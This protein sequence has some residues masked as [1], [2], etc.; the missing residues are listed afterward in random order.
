M[1]HAFGL[2]PRRVIRVTSFVAA[3]CIVLYLHSNPLL[4]L[5]RLEREDQLQP[6]PDMWWLK[7]RRARC[8]RVEP[9]R[10]G[11][12]SPGLTHDILLMKQLVMSSAV[13]GQWWHF[14]CSFTL[15]VTS[16]FLISLLTLILF[17]LLLTG[18]TVTIAVSNKLAA[19]CWESFHW[20]WESCILTR[21]NSILAFLA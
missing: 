21:I 19:I 12:F 13:L 10:T 1:Q 2:R 6:T 4:T 17:F 20:L 18:R 5:E 7:V 11:P 16:L 9:T 14:S 15:I 3:V 8:L